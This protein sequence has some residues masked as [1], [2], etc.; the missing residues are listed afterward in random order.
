MRLLI[1]GPGY[2][3]AHLIAR[4][5]GQ[6]DIAT[7][8]RASFA[9]RAADIAGPPH[10]LS[11]VP[12]GDD[13]PVLAAYRDEIAASGAWIGYLSSTGVY[14]D[15]GGAWVD[16]S[17][18]VGTGRRTPPPPRPRRRRRC[19]ARTGRPRFPPARHLWPGSFAARP[20][21]RRGGDT[22]RSAR[23]GV[24][25]RPCRGYRLGRDRRV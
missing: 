13:D 9:G 20:H 6:A 15:T 10:I 3:A 22:H 18:P 11:T 17:A 4:L 24:Q 1:F 16:E 7:V 25:P 23:P 2:T 8:T 19:L 12:R 14:G 5:A 21:P